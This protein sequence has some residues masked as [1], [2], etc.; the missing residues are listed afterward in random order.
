MFWNIEHRNCIHHT[1]ILPLLET[2]LGISV[3]TNKCFRITDL[4]TFW[5]I[6]RMGAVNLTK[7]NSLCTSRKIVQNTRI[8]S[9]FLFLYS[10]IFSIYEYWRCKGAQRASS[11][12]L[13]QLSRGINEKSINS[14][15][16]WDDA[17]HTGILFARNPSSQNI[18]FFC[19]HSIRCDDILCVKYSMTQLLRN[20]IE[21][22]IEKECGE[23]LL[24]T[25][26][27]KSDALSRGFFVWFL[28]GSG[29]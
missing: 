24:K 19:W 2:P 10:R 4:F 7:E 29:P 26:L 6:N 28:K 1:L 27:S 3:V 18:I 8:C 15:K 12:Y 17:L 20:K 11:N 25:Y 23:I 16:F 5:C 9:H 13:P 22:R 21:L 14:M